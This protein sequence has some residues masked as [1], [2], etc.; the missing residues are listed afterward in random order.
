MHPQSLAETQIC[1]LDEHRMRA[2]TYWQGCLGKVASPT[3]W[4][5]LGQRMETQFLETRLFC[6]VLRE[7]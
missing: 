1:F 5:E 2:A 7:P 4:T 6:T 3:S